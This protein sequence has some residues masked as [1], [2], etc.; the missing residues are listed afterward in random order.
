MADAEDP[1]DPVP[2]LRVPGPLARITAWLGPPAGYQLT[3]W[4]ILRL[5]GLVYV[6]AFIGLIAQGPALFGEHGLT[7]VGT[8]LEQLADAGMTGWDVPSILWWDSSD[9][10]MA[11]WAWISLALSLAFLIG[12]ANLPSLL[13]LW[14]I[15]GSFTRVGQLWFSF[16]WEIQLLETT[17]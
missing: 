15:Y 11:I 3:R 10:A 13:V 6:F 17:L 16:G 12:Y 5:L 4:L 14:I 9:R 2:D 7:P 1:P 8:Y